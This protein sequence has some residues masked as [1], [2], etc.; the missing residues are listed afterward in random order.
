MPE[1]RAGDRTRWCI[2]AAGQTCNRTVWVEDHANIAAAEYQTPLE[3]D[4]R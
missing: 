2:D 4:S 3:H 1:A